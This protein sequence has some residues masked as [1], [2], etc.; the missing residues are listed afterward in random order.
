MI[1]A[2]DLGSTN[3]KAALFTPDGR[4]VGESAEPLPYEVHTSTR[5]EL[6]PEAVVETFDIVLTRTL[7]GAG[8]SGRDVRRVALTSQAQ[9]F[10]ICDS[11]G[12]ANG[13]FTGWSDQRAAS[14]AEEL[15]SILG[16]RYHGTTGA[17]RPLSGQL[18]AQVLWSKRHVRT[19]PFSRFVTLP[20]YLAM[21]LGAPFVLD[22]NL[23]AMTGLYDIEGRAWWSAA[24]DAAGLRSEQLGILV[25]TG[26]AVPTATSE[27]HKMSCGV[28]PHEVILAGNDHTASALGCGCCPQRSVLTIGTAGVFYRRSAP[29][30]SGPFSSDG[31]WGPYPAGGF[32]ELRFVA[33]TCAALDWADG[34]LFGKIDTPGF[35]SA[36]QEAGSAGEVRFDPT[37]WGSPEA[38]TGQGTREQKALAVLQGIAAALHRLARL[39]PGNDQE[40]VVMGGGSR[41]DFWMQMLADLF[42][43]PL[44]RTNRDGLTG[45]AMLAGCTSVDQ[46]EAKADQVF[47]PNRPPT[48]G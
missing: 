41:V 18:A 48:E 30:A 36:A 47:H 31:M 43:S 46:D 14:E 28:A 40:I 45:A 2:A 15:R 9:T 24:L 19:D 17:P 44:I 16:D 35:V 38:W 25:E 8:V 34:F 32:Y 27:T 22:R 4:R 3:F 6:S 21:Q 39:P 11:N 37:R 1:L 13:L 26:E 33:D 20:S 29:P 10:C 42:G 23:A 5:A 12:V 7:Q